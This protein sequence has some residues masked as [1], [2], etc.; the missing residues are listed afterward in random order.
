MAI[1]PERVKALFQAAIKR[2]DPALRRAFLRDEVGNESC[3]HSRR[4]ALSRPVAE[5]TT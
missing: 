5:T 2:N 1:D 4:P 3:A